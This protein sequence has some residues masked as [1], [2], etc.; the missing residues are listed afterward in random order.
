VNNKL[1][2]RN[3]FKN[4][5]L[6]QVIMRLD[7]Q[8]VL[9]TEMENVLI[10]VKSFLKENGF[11][12]YDKRIENELEIPMGM[13]QPNLE[14]S[15]PNIK[16]IEVHSFT[17]ENKGYS[18]DLSVNFICLKVNE[19]KYIPFDEYA[20]VFMGISKIYNNNID[21]FT[22]KRFGLRKINFCFLKQL[23][24]LNK[25]FSTEYY[26]Y[27]KLYDN[28]NNLVSERKET[29]GVDNF[30]VNLLH[31]ISQ[32]QLDRDVIYKVVLDADI[33]IDEQEYIK[34]LIFDDGNIYV[35]N[36]KLFDIY[37]D[38]ITEEFAELLK[39]DDFDFSSEII[40][41]ERNE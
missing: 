36:N 12:R 39:K 20:D 24:K 11:T 26:N 9:P 18:I 25:Y 27:N 19:T 8:G 4:N 34:K 35:L 21:F 17:D 33:Y 40:G 6:K 5:I 28:T 32:G 2:E 14:I 41:V 29:F 31:G 22:V 1:L 16:S 37:I 10:P 15:G 23:N 30:K 38:A 7:F 3:A 13:I